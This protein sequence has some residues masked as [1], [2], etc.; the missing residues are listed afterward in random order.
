MSDPHVVITFGSA[1][2]NWCPLSH[3]PMDATVFDSADEARAY[4][5][6]LPEWMEAHILRVQGWKP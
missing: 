5:D 6:K 3:C 1:Q 2:P 4:A